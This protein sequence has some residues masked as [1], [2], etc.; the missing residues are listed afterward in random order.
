LLGWCVLEL[1]AESIDAESPQQTALDLF[2]RLRLRE[3]FAQAFGS[4][5]FEGEEGWRV[6]ARIKVVL[7]SEARIGQTEPIGE[8]PDPVSKTESAAPEAS[9]LGSE[10]VA[11][12]PDLWDDPDVRWLT[13]AHQADGHSYLV[14]EP[15]EE[16][17]WWLLM[18]ALLRIAA[19]P[20]LNRP[21]IVR[22]GERVDE[23][24]ASAEA[25]G[26]QI[27]T[28][29]EPP[30]ESTPAEPSEPAPTK[31]LEVTQVEEILSAPPTSD[32]SEPNPE[33]TPL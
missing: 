27:D 8:V 17:L 23:A 18:P 15:Y 25:A 12:A 29:R 11:L 9:A 14:R 32:A 31:P 7:L 28:L 1:L 26:Y 13:G 20:T 10:R 19:E 22:I 21:A 33:E 16:M 24:L 4:L 6:A 2:D 5:G 30:A 3:P